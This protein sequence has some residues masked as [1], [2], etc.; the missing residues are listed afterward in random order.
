MEKL[1]IKDI[2]DP[3]INLRRVA[4]RDLL[5]SEYPKKI[6]ILKKRLSVESDVQ[7]KY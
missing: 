5:S 1:N 7:L 6:E 2:A 4:I 3:D